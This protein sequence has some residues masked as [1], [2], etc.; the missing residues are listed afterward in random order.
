MI[1]CAFGLFRVV[2]TLQKSRSILDRLR[3]TQSTSH[4]QRE[5]CKWALTRR[6]LE[7]TFSTIF[8]SCFIGLCLVLEPSISS[9]AKKRN[10]RG[11]S[12]NSLFSNTGGGENKVRQTNKQLRWHLKNHVSAKLACLNDF[13]ADNFQKSFR[14]LHD[15]FPLFQLPIGFHLKRMKINEQLE[16]RTSSLQSV[17][18]CI[19]KSGW[20][21]KACLHCLTTII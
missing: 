19:F 13:F 6:D 20:I 12:L 8:R 5:Y 1:Y 15:F 4:L 10:N 17:L 11:S 2:S 7:M 16:F 21:R 9:S 14:F 18:W 3:A